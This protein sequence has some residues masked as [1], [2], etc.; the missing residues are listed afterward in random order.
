MI[1]ARL[2]LTHYAL[3]SQCFNQRD[4]EGANIEFSRAIEYYPANAEYYVNRAR[5]SLE[6]PQGFESAYGDLQ[7]ALEID[8]A[9][10]MASAL[11]QN[12]NRDKRVQFVNG[13]F[14]KPL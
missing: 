5:A 9:H 1:K 3:G 14:V 4:Y 6:M 12:F 8:P 10:D 11:I 2:S 13:K 7:K